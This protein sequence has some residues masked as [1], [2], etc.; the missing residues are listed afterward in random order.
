MDDEKNIAL[1]NYFKQGDDGKINLDL[2]DHFGNLFYKDNNTYYE[3]LCNLNTNDTD[4]CTKRNIRRHK[5]ET[6][7][8][9]INPC[10]GIQ[11]IQKFGSGAVGAA[12]LIKNRGN[13][14]EIPWWVRDILPQYS[15]FEIAKK[16]KNTHLP[17]Y[18][19][20]EIKELT[21]ENLKIPSIISNK[22]MSEDKSYMVIANADNFANQTLINMML[23]KILNIDDSRIRKK[24]SYVKQLDAYYCKCNN[25][26][27][28]WSLMEWANLGSLN[29]YLE[30]RHKMYVIWKDVEKKWK[31]GDEGDALELES[32][33]YEVTVNDLKGIIADV[34]RPLLILKSEKYGFVHADM[35]ATNIFV[36]SEIKEEDAQMKYKRNN[37]IY[38]MLA[39]FDKS[40]IFYNGVRFHNQFN[41]NSNMFLST[42]FNFLLPEVTHPKNYFK[43]E[44]Y[45]QNIFMTTDLKAKMVYG[46]AM[47]SSLPVP[48]CLDIYVFMVSLCFI[49][50][51]FKLILDDSTENNLLKEIWNDLFD[52]SEKERVDNAVKAAYHEIIKQKE[53]LNQTKSKSLTQ[54]RKD[55]IKKQID[56]LTGMTAITKILM[57]F[58]LKTDALYLIARR[59][60]EENEFNGIMAY[61]NRELSIHY[62]EKLYNNKVTLATNLTGIDMGAHICVTPCEK[63]TCKTN[64]Y[65]QATVLSTRIRNEGR[66]NKEINKYTLPTDNEI[67]EIFKNLE[68]DVQ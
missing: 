54:S 52:T 55:A 68:R 31:E 16:I 3:C 14:R 12:Y 20:L 18:I 65:S 42:G 27:T 33:E 4:E 44:T 23:D 32:K 38:A 53:L 6:K 30:E 9:K 24:P 5:R 1:D 41:K 61:V 15:Q 37:R 45:A 66:C 2:T 43:P 25:E 67:D 10:E 58:H 28:S 19:S 8:S 26:Y 22:F 63:N 49:T 40:S 64:T 13:I 47:Y 57:N 48:M 7:K 50:P 35:K 21:E 46:T 51:V 34:I 60:L 56:G 29:D 62:H 36:G 39:D 59:V 11:F 17:K